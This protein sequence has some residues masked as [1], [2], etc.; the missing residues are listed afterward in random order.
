MQRNCMTDKTIMENMKIS[1]MERED[2]EDVCRIERETFSVP[3]T[4]K[5]FETSLDAKDTCYLTAKIHDRIVGYCG[6]L[7]VLEEADITN[8]AVDASFRGKGIGYAMLSELL[9]CGN[10]MGIC[11]FTLEV[12]KSNASAIALYKKLGFEDCGIRKN[13]YEKPLED[14]VIMWKK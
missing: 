13:F 2:L 8:V 9:R 7:M 12:R 3:W 10:A 4:K 11:A 1:L 14:A 6:M 5:G